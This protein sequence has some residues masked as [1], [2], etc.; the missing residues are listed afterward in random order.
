MRRFVFLIVLINITS[1]PFVLCAPQIQ[2]RS[3]TEV[4]NEAAALKENFRYGEA[5]RILED[6]SANADN[7]IRVQKYLAKLYYLSAKP[8]PAYK[9]LKKIKNKDWECFLYLGL[10]FEG[11]DKKEIAADS[12]L[13]SLEMRKNSIALYRLGKIYYQLHQY[14]EAVRFFSQCLD[15]DPSIRLANYY[16]G[17]CLFRIKDF[18]EAYSYAARGINFYPDNEKMKKQLLEVKGRLG[19]GFFAQMRRII[20]RTRRTVN[21]I[22]YKR[23]QNSPLLKV[24]LAKD[25]R[26]FSFRAGESFSCSDGRKTFNGDKDKY[27]T[28]V[29]KNKSVFLFENGSSTARAKLKTPITILGSKYPFYILDVVYGKSNYWHKQIDRMYRGDLRLNS[30]GQGMTLINILSMEEYLYG[31]LPSEIPSGA[32]KEAL[33]A[34]AIAARTIAI[35]NSGRHKTEGFD[36]CSQV[37][38]QAYQGMSAETPATNAAVDGTK[39]EVLVQGKE[40]RPIEAFYHANCGGC[41]RSDIFGGAEYLSNKF[42]APGSFQKPSESTF[43]P[44]YD[45]E[46]WIYNEP[47]AYCAYKKSSFRWQRIY[48][49]EDFQL[50]FGF[51]LKSIKSIVPLKKGQCG[52]YDSLKIETL[53]KEEALSGDLRIREYFDKL[54]SSAF[55][56]EIKFSADNEAQM[57]I[58]YGAGFGH[59]AGLC[60]E[61]A[62]GMASEGHTYEEILRHY[63]P[64][65]EIKAVY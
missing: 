55:R 15:N 65:T 14:G 33:R 41:L 21:F 49:A 6:F 46:N 11:L 34:Q 59:A 39:G 13:K 12:Y 32:P 5:I 1:G 42:D 25:L 40:S 3:G 47:P 2:N 38:C 23:A 7:D 63:Y 4:L 9:I 53:S 10:I 22:F 36:V 62:M 18:K 24:G 45:A 51:P 64:N 43:L 27:Y 58:F 28:F 48:D 57:L 19:E 60:Q 56:V 31:V 61:G 54:R 30:G 44:G 20:E 50:A 16:L 52:H 8:I 17:D 29:Y 37:H 26:K 35:K